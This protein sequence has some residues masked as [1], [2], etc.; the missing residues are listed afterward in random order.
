MFLSSSTALMKSKTD[1][2]LIYGLKISVNTRNSVDAFMTWLGK[3]MH[4]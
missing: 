2:L 1:I 3:A 4:W